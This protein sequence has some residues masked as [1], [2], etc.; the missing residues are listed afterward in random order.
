VIFQN[1]PVAEACQLACK[2]WNGLPAKQT[3]NHGT[4]QNPPDLQPNTW[5]LIRFQEVS[6]GNGG[7][8]WIF[9]HDACMHC[10]D[11]A[12]VKVCPSGAL[13]HTKYGTVALDEAKCIGCKECMFACPFE[14]PKYD[15]EKDK[16]AKCDM[17]FSRIAND[18]E[19]ACVKACP[20][21]AL[22]FGDKDKM[23]KVAC[24]RV[25]EL[26]GDASVYGDKYVGGTHVIYVLPEE[27]AKR[28]MG[29]NRNV[30][31]TIAGGGSGVGIKQVGEGLVDIGNTGRMPTD[32]EIKRY[33]LNMFKFAIDGIA[34]IV[35][36]NNPV[37]TMSKD[38]IMD[39][40]SGRLDNWKVPGWKDR[41]INIYTRDASSG[42]RKVFWKKAL[43]KGE[44]AKAA[45]FVK[46]HGAMKSAISMDPY[47]I[48]YISAGY[49]DDTVATVAIDGVSPTLPNVR[50]GNYKIARGLYMNTKGKP[51]KK[52]IRL[53]IDYILSKEGQ[54]I[55]EENGFI[56]VK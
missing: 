34:V 4:Y 47:G 49:L 50:K 5:N 40:F 18:L 27:A 30:K 26:G 8:K 12:C 44:I 43:N 10:T 28:I 17:C 46:S 31:I 25:E 24:K 39:I 54:K 23:L 53:F 55:V 7:V 9:R 36:P 22:L 15:P 51:S 41:G 38:R 37:A 42:T 45:N 19:P 32:D 48:G 1:A 52:L 6:D 13:H 29:V 20:T 3:Y 33:G 56:A 16:I 35:N 21:G 14:V 11:A 2:Q